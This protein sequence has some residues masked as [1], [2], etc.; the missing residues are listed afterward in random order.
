M[1]KETQLSLPAP[2]AHAQHRNQVYAFV[3]TVTLIVYVLVSCALFVERLI[4]QNDA[5]VM[6]AVLL[7]VLLGL[8]WKNLGHGRH[9]CFLF[10]AILTLVQGGRL[11]VYCLGVDL[12]PLRVANITGTSFDISR[13]A[14]G[15][16]LLAVGSSALL[17]YLPCRWCYRSI[18]P[19]PTKQVQKYLPYL[20]LLF[21]VSLPIQAYK[22]YAYYQVAQANGGYLYFYVNHAAFASSV[23]FVVRLVSLVAFPTFVA[24]FAFETRRR[25]VWMVGI[26]YFCS[27][28][29]VLLL[30]SRFG[31]FGLLLALWYAAG[32]KSG[33]KSRFL[34][35][36][37]LGL[38][39]LVAS[40]VVQ[41][42]REEPDSMQGY[43]FAPLRFISGQGNSLD[44][45]ELA[46][47]YPQV[48]SPYG[49]SY[50]WN[51]LSDAFVPRDAS[52][53]VRGRRFGDDVT[54]FLNA[55]AF[56]TGL[57]TS[58]S[59]IAECYVV[60]GLTG[61]LVIS[62]LVGCGL[63][64]LY[65]A[66]GT[67]IGLF[68]VVMIL[69]DVISMTRGQ[70]LDWISVLLRSFLYIG[71]LAMGWHIYRVVAWLKRAPRLAV[72]V[73]TSAQQFERSSGSANE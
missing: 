35:A 32:V 53:Y 21:F 42:H 38:V 64:L 57:G 1:Q 26:L 41:S 44:V 30:G 50:L 37:G 29:L 51:E 34:W 25:R 61:V 63:H 43:T 13:G 28:I 69:P 60:G 18:G 70:L 17:V 72:V 52:D 55:S 19:L 68:V 31:T 48:F 15:L 7:C 39:L 54:V 23:P 24:L 71:V 3:E 16:S 4:S 2:S 12:D 45:T 36:I 11:L 33:R 46:I 65:R 62:V 58:S 20:Y 73:P 9:P 14:A 47:A 59:Y 10:L 66:S 5:A 8:S 67:P 6:S 56:A 40:Q 22:N 49:T 27:S